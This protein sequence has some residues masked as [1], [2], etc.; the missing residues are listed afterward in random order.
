LRFAYDACEKKDQI[1]RE[2]N[3]H[4]KLNIIM[5]DL[6]IIKD[7]SNTEK[8]EQ[9]LKNTEEF[10]QRMDNLAAAIRLRKNSS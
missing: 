6:S 10:Y 2:W 9:R 5:E 1:L 7:Q 8:A 3:I 4:E